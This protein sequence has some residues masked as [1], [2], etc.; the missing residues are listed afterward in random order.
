VT[1]RTAAANFTQQTLAWFQQGEDLENHAREAAARREARL[2][3]RR[4]RLRAAAGIV[5]LLLL[6]GMLAFLIACQLGY[7]LE[8][9]WGLSLPFDLPWQ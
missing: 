6:A 5:V 7:T 2:Q 4:G 1:N 9:P 3:A 8:L